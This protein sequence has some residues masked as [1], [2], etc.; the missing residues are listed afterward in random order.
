MGKRGLQPR[1]WRGEH[2]LAGDPVWPPVRCWWCPDGACPSPDSGGSDLRP[3]SWPQVSRPGDS[4][5]SGI[6]PSAGS[7]SFHKQAGQV[8]A[9]IEVAYAAFP[10]QP[11]TPPCKRWIGKQRLLVINRRDR[12]MKRPARPGTFAAQPGRDPWWCD[13]RAGTGVKKTAGAACGLAGSSMPAGPVAACC[14]AGRGP[15]AGFPTWA[16]RPDQPAGAPEGG[17]TAPPAGVTPHPALG[18]GSAWTSICSTPPAVAARQGAGGGGGR[19]DDP[20]SAC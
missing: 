1:A 14:A 20:A 7:A 6:S 4:V 16:S 9:V 17:G 13:A 19:L 2:R 10:A 15:D 18:S 12:F 11:G 8:D 3:G 5:V